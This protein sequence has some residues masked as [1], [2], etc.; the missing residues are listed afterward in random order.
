[1][2]LKEFLIYNWKL[3]EK[4]QK[5]PKG[6]KRPFRAS[7]ICVI[8]MET[9]TCK[10]FE[11]Q[12]CA[13]SKT[14]RKENI[15]MRKQVARCTYS[16]THLSGSIEINVWSMI[17]VWV[18]EFWIS[19][20]KEE[21]E[22]KK[23]RKY[24]ALRVRKELTNSSCRSCVCLLNGYFRQFDSWIEL[25]SIFLMLRTKF[26]HLLV[27]ITFFILFIIVVRKKELLLYICC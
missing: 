26:L 12:T 1:M 22:I 21:I 27:S 24:Y 13:K 2:V 20:E 19:I 3:C 6:R 9:S 15:P 14:S 10:W 23:E 7:E 8:Q 5:S 4:C 18:W 11:W 17:S 25:H 16:A